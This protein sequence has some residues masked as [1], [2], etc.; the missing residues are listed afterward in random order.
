[1]I[2]D[3]TCYFLGFNSYL[4]A[5]FT[6]SLLNRSIVKQFLQSIVFKDAKRPYTK[7]ILM[8]LDLSRTASRLSF[9]ALYN[10]W[11]DMGYTPR[12]PVTESD[13]EEYKKRLLIAAGGPQSLQLNLDI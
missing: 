9:L 12:V 6:A 1:V 13:L 4:D 7:E 10:L 11:A 8:R 3:D 5:L 2:L